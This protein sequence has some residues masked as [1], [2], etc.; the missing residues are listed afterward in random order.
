MAP[1]YELAKVRSSN[2][3]LHMYR[4]KVVKPENQTQMHMELVNRRKKTTLCKHG[5]ETKQDIRMEKVYFRID[6]SIDS[7]GH[8]KS[9]TS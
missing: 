8:R 2:G 5:G 3:R 9:L 7:L 6:Y 1:I 4:K